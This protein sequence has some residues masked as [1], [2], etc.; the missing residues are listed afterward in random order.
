LNRLTDKVAIVTGAGSG[1]GKSIVERFLAEGCSGIIAADITGQQQEVAKHC[2]AKVVPVQAD[3]AV[4]GDIQAMVT[5]ARRRWGRLDILINNAGIAGAR[6]SLHEVE[7][8]EFD[9]IHAVNVKGQFL[10]M[11]YAIPLMLETGGGAIINMASIG[12]LVAQPGASAYL[13]SKGADLMLT[14]GAALEYARQ[15]IRINAICPGT[16]DTGILATLDP[17]ARQHYIDLHPIGRLGR[18]EE[19]ASMAVF[20]ASDEASFC[21]GGAYVVDGGR[22]AT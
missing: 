8:A 1:I 22:T 9:R 15:N 5:E 2:G 7:E 18:P 10:A 21:I 13:S 11:K 3:V 4:S 20:L 16:I 12:A 6:K 17:S 19:I 14:R